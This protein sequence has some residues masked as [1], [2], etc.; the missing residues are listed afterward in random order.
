MYYNIADLRQEYSHKQLLENEIDKDP[1]KQFNLWW[2]DAIDA[3]VPEPNAMVL[4]TASADGV[5]SARV[6]LLKGISSKGF[7]FYT[8]YNSF[9]GRQLQENPKACLVFHWK[10]LERQVR[11]TGVVEKISE[12][13]SEAYFHSR[14]PSSQ[15]GA[16]ASPQSEVIPNRHWLDE[17]FEK[18]AK[19]LHNE[20]VPKP[21]H[22]GGYAVKPVIIEFWQG[23]PSRMHDRL[24]YSLQDDGQWKIER[25]AP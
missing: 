16:V 9:K 12:K 5:P 22:W 7:I 24:Q 23:R 11:I 18:L 13:E 21:Q 2:K 6:I 19:E 14:P 17:E 20:L 10:E 1:V 4:A 8:N 15:I 25:L 3:K